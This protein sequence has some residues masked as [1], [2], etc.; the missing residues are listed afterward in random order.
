M[1]LSMRFPGWIGPWGGAVCNDPKGNSSCLLIKNI[2]PK[3]DDD[4]DQL[5]AGQPFAQLGMRS[6]VPALEVLR[7]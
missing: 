7:I 2:G 3:R 5:H 4:F 6:G 1:H